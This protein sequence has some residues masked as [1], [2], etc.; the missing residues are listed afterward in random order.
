[1]FI[2]HCSTYTNCACRR[3]A[4]VGQRT[5]NPL[6]RNADFELYIHLGF[7]G[8]SLNSPNG[9]N[10]GVGPVLT[11]HTLPLALAPP[12]PPSQSACQCAPRTPCASLDSRATAEMNADALD[13][14]HQLA[15]IVQFAM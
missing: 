15:G 1:V 12:D 4:S 8:R 9:W 11:L 2:E 6:N 10:P 7:A 14:A 3:G 13:M 5:L